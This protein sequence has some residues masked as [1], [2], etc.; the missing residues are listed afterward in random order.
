MPLSRTREEKAERFMNLLPTRQVFPAR[1]PD[2]AF[3][4]VEVAGIGYLFP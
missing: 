1:T 2:P 3:P 4:G